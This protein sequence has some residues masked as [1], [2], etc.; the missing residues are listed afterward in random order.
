VGRETSEGKRERLAETA[1]AT[2]AVDPALRLRFF[3]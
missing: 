2:L 3:L 1:K